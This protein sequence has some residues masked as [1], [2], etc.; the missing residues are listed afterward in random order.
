MLL[1][2]ASTTETAIADSTR[3][4]GSD[5]IQRRQRQRQRMGQRECRDHLEHVPQRRL[6]PCRR[7]PGHAVAHQ[8][9]GQQQR[10]QEQDVIE[11][12]PDVPHAVL[13]VFDELPQPVR[14]GENQVLGRRLDSKD[15]GAH[16][17][18]VI[19]LQQAA[20]LRVEVEQQ[21][22]SGFQRS[23][24]MCAAR[25]EA[26]H[27][28]GAIAVTIDQVRDCHGRTRVAIRGQGQTGQ[29]VRGDIGVTR[30]HLAPGDGAV[31]VSVQPERE[32]QVAQR[33]IPLTVDFGA[34]DPQRQVAVTRLVCLGNGGEGQQESGKQSTE[35]ACGPEC[36]RRSSR[37][38]VR[39]G[40]G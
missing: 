7:L 25:R 32:V 19:E 24:R 5:H 8:H 39:T 36:H 2:A 40:S 18:A 28:V 29:C 16:L 27:G 14:R 33:D 15:R 13:K 21:P 22:V 37:L 30:T 38:H 20:M 3:R 10:Q 31:L 9:R 12:E 35:N 1:S 4:D 34:G 11:A 6:Q 23:R 17:A 26:Q